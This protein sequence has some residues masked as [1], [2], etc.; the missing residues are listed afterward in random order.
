M[1]VLQGDD[2]VLY[3]ETT[4]PGT[5][6]VVNDISEFSKSVTRDSS[7]VRVF[8]RA[9][10]YV[11]TGGRNATYTATGFFNPT[12]P[13]QQ[14]LRDMEAVDTPVKIR[15]LYDGTNGFTQEVKVTSYDYG[16]SAEPG[17][18]TYGF[19]LEANADAVIVGTGPIL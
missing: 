1:A 4:T 18:Q 15:L 12:D 14:R 5:F 3:V 17:L 8:A 2:F 13:G 11:V 19:D 6:V 16:A 7:Q 9:T 10:P